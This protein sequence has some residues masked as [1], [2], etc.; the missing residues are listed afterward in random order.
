MCTR[1][2][3]RNGTSYLTEFREPVR[4]SLAS[5]D[6]LSCTNRERGAKTAHITW[7]CE[8]CLMK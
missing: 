4:P 7:G 2:C 1:L 6:G 5:D 3:A 8:K